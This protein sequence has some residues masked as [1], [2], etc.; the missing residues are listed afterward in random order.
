PLYY[1]R[2]RGEQS[3]HLSP[4][5]GAWRGPDRSAWVAS[6]AYGFERPST[7]PDSAGIMR[8]GGGFAP[9]FHHEI[10]RDASAQTVGATTTL[11]P[12]F[13]RDR[14]P[15]RDL[16]IW[17]P[18]IWRAK[19]RGEKPRS[20]FAIA[21][22][23]FHQRQPGGVDV[24]AGLLFFWSRDRTRR[25][26]TLVAGPFYHR[27]QRDKLLTGLGPLAYWEDSPKRRLL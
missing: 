26:H 6:L 11:F 10:R 24:D 13:L 9:L 18:L 2:Q 27:L 8:K 23:Y 15:E 5:G 17:T 19:V 1:R 4:L 22:L 21:P 12:L 20:N 14:R 3:L 16:D 7:E 25:T